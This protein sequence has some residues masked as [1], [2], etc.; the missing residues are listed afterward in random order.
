MSE[1]D[2]NVHIQIICIMLAVGHQWQQTENDG[3]HIQIE[4]KAKEVFKQ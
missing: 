1:I 2:G 3:N 4:T